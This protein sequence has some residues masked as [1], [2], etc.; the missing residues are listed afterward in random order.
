MSA[1]SFG[2][3]VGNPVLESDE[4]QAETITTIVAMRGVAGQNYPK[5]KERVF[6]FIFGFSFG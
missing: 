3:L 5:L 4:L 2:R 1:Y 6:S